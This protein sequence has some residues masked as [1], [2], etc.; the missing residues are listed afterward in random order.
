MRMT[1]LKI[2]TLLGI[3]SGI[4][5]LLFL[6]TCAIAIYQMGNIQSR[7]DAIVQENN[8]KT[9]VVNDLKVAVLSASEAMRTLPLLQDETLMAEQKRRYVEAN[10]KYDS[11]WKA[12]SG[13]KLG[14]QEREVVSKV[15]AAQERVRKLNAEIVDLA[16]SSRVTEATDLILNQAGTATSAVLDQMTALHDTG[17]QE[18]YQGASSARGLATKVM[19][20]LSILVPLLAALGSWL[21]TRAVTGPLHSA[22]VAA[23]D[24]A[25]GDLSQKLDVQGKSEAGDVMRALKSMNDSL[26]SVVIK[27]RGGAN[28]INEAAR[29]LSAGAA[30]LSSRTESTASSLEQTAASMEELMATV[31]R[32]AENAKQAASLAQ[33]ASDIATRGGEAVAQVVGNMDAISGSAKRI[34]D[35]ITVMDGIA[36]QTNILALNAAVEAA[37]AGD[38]GRGFAVV[39]AEVR[40]L[41]QRSTTAAKEIK[42][43][44]GDSVSRIETGSKL[45]SEASATMGKIVSTNQDVRDIVRDISQA[46]HEQSRGIEEVKGA[47]DE[48]DRVTEQNAALV[49]ELAAATDSMRDQA[50]SLLQGVEFFK[51]AGGEQTYG[52]VE[53]PQS[54]YQPQA[55]VSTSQTTSLPPRTSSSHGNGNSDEWQ[56]F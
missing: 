24:V 10:V 39:A 44:I 20:V 40:A 16:M 21:V 43:L 53:E 1:N 54:R 52:F 32:N 12:L 30:Q 34:V 27:V 47:I 8:L 33:Q 5:V 7:L 15:A 25:R 4:V 51:V 11:A 29:E 26:A 45:V 23:N 50:E 31:G 2:G 56:S 41:A 48:M 3:S 17:T 22:V 36:F 42:N 18:A 6:F 37:R 13:M 28:N 9:K 14:A 46:S 19:V 38:H 49:E 35:I 55:Q